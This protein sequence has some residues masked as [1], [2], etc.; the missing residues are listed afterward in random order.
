ML[1][2]CVLLYLLNYP[3]EISDTGICQPSERIHSCVKFNRAMNFGLGGILHKSSWQ[4]FCDLPS[5]A[6]RSHG[7]HWDC[8]ESASASESYPEKNNIIREVRRHTRLKP[9]ELKALCGIRSHPLFHNVIGM[10]GHFFHYAEGS[11]MDSKDK[12]LVFLSMYSTNDRPNANT[13]GE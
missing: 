6:E 11:C 9:T 8:T 10:V 2:F 5:P 7:D 3:K 12:T 1:C 4:R 13:N